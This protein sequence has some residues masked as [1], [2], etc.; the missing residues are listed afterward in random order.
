MVGS[1]SGGDLQRARLKSVARRALADAWARGKAQSEARKIA[2]KIIQAKFP[3]MK[4]DEIS[5]LIEAIR[6]E[7]K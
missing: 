2:V 1:P 5:D 4:K 3:N 6:S 7:P